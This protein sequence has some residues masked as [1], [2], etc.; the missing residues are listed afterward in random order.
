MVRYRAVPRVLQVIRA[1]RTI[2]TI[3]TELVDAEEYFVKREEHPEKVECDV[4][5]GKLT[6]LRDLGVEVLRDEFDH[7]AQLEEPITVRFFACRCFFV[8]TL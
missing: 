8:F 1:P 6:E 7:S 5:L 3:L 4:V 2:G